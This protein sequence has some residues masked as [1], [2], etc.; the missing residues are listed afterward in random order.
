M[1]GRRRLTFATVST[2]CAVVVCCAVAAGTGT[3]GAAPGAPPADAAPRAALASTGTSPAWEVIEQVP[4]ITTLDDG[5][6]AQT[7]A[8]SCAAVGACS[9][10]GFYIDG[11]DKQDQAFVVSESDGVWGSPQEE[12]GVAQLNSGG[13]ASV[14]AIS[15]FAAGECGV[16]GYY[17]DNTGIQTFVGSQASGTWDGSIQLPGSESGFGEPVSESCPA[18]A[19]CTVGGFLTDVH[20]NDQPYVDDQ[21]PSF[22]WR[23][24]PSQTGEPTMGGGSARVTSVSCKS[25]GNCTAGGWYSVDFRQGAFVAD[26]VNGA[27]RPA[28]IVAGSLNKGGN[29]QV[30]QVS[31]AAAGNCAA[32]GG[33]A[34]AA[35]QQTPFVKEEKS[36]V[37]GPAV[38][39]PGVAALNTF[40]YAAATSVSCTAPGDCT[41][42]GYYNIAKTK[43]APTTQAD[44]VATEKNGVWGTAIEVPGMGALNT[45]RAGTPGPVSCVSP[46]TCSAA[47][48]Y[49]TAGGKF[50]VWS[51]SERGGKWANAAPLPGLISVNTGDSEVNGLSCA[52]VSS[53]GLVG[54]YTD[55]HGLEQPFVAT[56]AIAVSTQVSETL[57]AH[58]VVYGH[59]QAE[60]VFVGTAS[61]FGAYPTGTVAIKAGSSGAVTACVITL[62]A[63]E[64]SC[65]VPAAKFGPG[66]VA[67]TAQY[68]GTPELRGSTSGTVTFTVT[69]AA[70]RTGLALSAGTITYG[71][72]Q[73]EHLTV[74]VAPQ[75]RGIPAGIVTVTA[76]TVTVCVIKA[77]KG[78]CTLASTRL[79]AGTYHL[80]ARYNGGA[81]FKGSSSPPVTLTVVR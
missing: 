11:S 61:Q 60:R 76:G 75:Y 50:Q 26:E 58:T 22:D 48:G 54:Y 51:D 9:A 45:G 64:G 8:V 79:K 81:D 72:E 13:D 24:D 42:E 77:P 27:W 44:F 68:G 4:G 18:F 28:G 35:N 15:C 3:A 56:G 21:G 5:G 69:K 80:V 25:A 70:T 10:G 17:S 16:S 55:S 14:T 57:S 33:Y 34:P 74:R 65:L 36:G 46:G 47:G 43:T 52:A 20:G 37:W 19:R 49:K 71:H 41:V 63:G 38:Q 29:A 12:P 66:Q 62:K 39:L 40:H 30:S 2:A 59:E 53:C 67:L 7:K 23:A 73:A 6:S 78:S 31:C 1:S 32:V